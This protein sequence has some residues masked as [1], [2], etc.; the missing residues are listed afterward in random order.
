MQNDFAGKK[1]VAFIPGEHVEGRGFR[2]AFAV[3]GERGYFPTG[4]WPYT[5][6]AG[7][8]MPWFWGPTIE[9][10]RRHAAAH[11]E[12]R[13]IGADEATRIVVASMRRE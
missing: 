8:T 11:N 2:V 5:G 7:E 12:R 3:E 9:D 4:T 13:G 6:A 1:L 10:A